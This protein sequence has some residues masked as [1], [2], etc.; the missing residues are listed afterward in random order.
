VYHYFNSWLT[1]HIATIGRW[2][3]NALSDYVTYVIQHAFRTVMMECLDLNACVVL[4]GT[5]V[6]KHDECPHILWWQCNT[7]WVHTWQATSSFWLWWYTSTNNELSCKCTT[8]GLQPADVIVVLQRGAFNVSFN[9]DILTPYS[10]S[11][12]ASRNILLVHKLK[13]RKNR[14]W[15]PGSTW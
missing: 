5:T 9:G 15:Q 2:M 7:V 1:M 8:K 4:L 6:S 12:Y 13:E 11:F 14:P 10:Y 3:H